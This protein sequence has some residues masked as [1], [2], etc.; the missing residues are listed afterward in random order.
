MERAERLV[1]RTRVLIQVTQLNV[2][3]QHVCPAL[4]LLVGGGRSPGAPALGPPRLACAPRRDPW[5]PRGRRACGRW[6]TACGGRLPMRDRERRLRRVTT[7]MTVRQR[8]AALLAAGPGNTAVYDD[9]GR[10]LTPAG[11]AAFRRDCARFDQLNARVAL[12]CH[13]C[14]LRDPDPRI[15]PG[16]VLGGQITSMKS[17]SGHC[18][19]ADPLRSPPGSAIAPPIASKAS[20]APARP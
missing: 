7:R 2:G 13:T 18:T 9:I 19:I 14:F 16:S 4:R 15:G 20:R 10:G 12:P 5:P 11:W 17:M 3:P 1:S 6:R 8:V